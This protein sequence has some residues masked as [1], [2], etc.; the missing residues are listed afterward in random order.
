ML[1]W[2]IPRIY[3]LHSTWIDA[4]RDEWNL[5]SIPFADL[6]GVFTASKTTTTPLPARL[7]HWHQRQRPKG[8][9]IASELLLREH[10]TSVEDRDEYEGH[11]VFPATMVR[12][13]Q[14]PPRWKNIPFRFPGWLR[15]L[16]IR[17]GLWSGATSNAHE[18]HGR[19]GGIDR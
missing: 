13:V 2:L 10:E 4:R 8:R 19:G 3:A 5:R 6:L 11:G 7:R 16:C 9:S 15:A 17:P 18:T 12:R 14:D 1:S